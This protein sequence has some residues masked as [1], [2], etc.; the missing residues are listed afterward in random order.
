MQPKFASIKVTNPSPPSQAQLK[1]AVSKAHRRNVTV[2]VFHFIQ[3]GAHKDDLDSEF[4]T[5][6]KNLKR[7]PPPAVD[8]WDAALLPSKIY[9]DLFSGSRISISLPRYTMMTI[10]Y[11]YRSKS[12]CR[13]SAVKLTVKINAIVFV[14]VSSLSSLTSLTLTLLTFLVTQSVYRIS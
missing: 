2:A 5:L 10:I 9:D 11:H 8:W 4:E 7:E 6:E 13:N 3:K 14:W 1:T 12:R